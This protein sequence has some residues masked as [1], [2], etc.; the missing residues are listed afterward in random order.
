MASRC[1]PQ[2]ALHCSAVVFTRLLAGIW[3][4]A[5]V[6][7]AGGSPLRLVPPE[8]FTVVTVVGLTVWMA[9]ALAARPSGVIRRWRG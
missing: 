2:A 9:I 8:I 7:L 1:Q 6:G 5:V 3:A 4:A